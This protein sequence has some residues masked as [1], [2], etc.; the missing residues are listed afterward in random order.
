M[1]QRPIVDPWTILCMI[2]GREVSVV[3]EGRAFRKSF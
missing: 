1:P 2:L 3:G